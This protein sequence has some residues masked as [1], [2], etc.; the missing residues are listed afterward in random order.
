MYSRCD[1]TLDWT[2]LARLGLG[3]V[4]DIVVL[5]PRPAFHMKKSGHE[6]DIVFLLTAKEK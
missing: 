1:G 3:P 4:G 5:V 2:S 6:N